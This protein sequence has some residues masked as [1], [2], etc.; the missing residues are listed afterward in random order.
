M[1][2]SLLRHFRKSLNNC[3]SVAA[4]TVL[5]QSLISGN[6]GTIVLH[7]TPREMVCHL[8][9][10]FQRSVRRGIFLT[11]PRSTRE[12]EGRAFKRKKR[13]LSRPLKIT[14]LLIWRFMVLQKVVCQLTQTLFG[15]SERWIISR[16]PTNMRVIRGRLSETIS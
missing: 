3:R 16:H 15:I 7:V 1:S 5:C 10:V 11:H 14:I 6:A 12:I 2:S 8:I 13:M 4:L 9:K